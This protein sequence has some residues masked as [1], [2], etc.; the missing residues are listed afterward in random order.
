VTFTGKIKKQGKSFLK[1][2]WYNAVILSAVTVVLMVALT[3]LEGFIIAF[4]LT[5]EITFLN[6]QIL[7]EITVTAVFGVV[8]LFLVSPLTI[9]EKRWYGHLCNS[10]SLKVTD[11]FYFYKSPKRY[12]KSVWI[13]FR[14]FIQ[15]FVYAILLLIVPITAFSFSYVS[16]GNSSHLSQGLGIVSLFLGTGFLAVGIILFVKIY[17]GFSLSTYI[18]SM[19]EQYKTSKAISLSKKSVNKNEAKLIMFELSFLLFKITQLL[20]IPIFFVLPYY[21][22]SHIVLNEKLLKNHK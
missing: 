16:F 3:A 19:N 4:D 10:T 18:F 7:T 6:F 9:G 17:L 2:N 22:A 12:F 20:I 15:L 13:C 1:G 14:I 8:W 11:V 21:N 5:G